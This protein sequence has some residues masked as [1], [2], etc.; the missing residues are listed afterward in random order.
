[1]VNFPGTKKGT[2][3]FL[4]RSVYDEKDHFWICLCVEFLIY[5]AFLLI[6]L[7]TDLFFSQKKMCGKLLPVIL[8]KMLLFSLP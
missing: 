4:L 7:P 1:M 6:T 5:Y 2:D 8:E 3:P